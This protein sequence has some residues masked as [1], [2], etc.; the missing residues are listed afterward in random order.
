MD[1]H[2]VIVLYIANVFK[3]Q[4]QDLKRG[5]AAVHVKTAVKHLVMDL[6]ILLPEG[7]V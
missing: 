2:L 1:Y 3:Q 4:G 6:I 7:W 5:F